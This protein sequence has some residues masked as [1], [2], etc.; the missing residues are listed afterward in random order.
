MQRL[1]VLPKTGEQV[2][3]GQKQVRGGETYSIR[4]A[5]EAT[6]TLTPDLIDDHI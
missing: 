2:W 3:R 5:S 6:Q 4:R 1:R